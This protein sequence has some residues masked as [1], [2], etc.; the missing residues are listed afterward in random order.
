[1]IITKWN[2]LLDSVIYKRESNEGMMAIVSVGRDRE[3]NCSTDT[4]S[5]KQYTT[6]ERSVAI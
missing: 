5:D 2:F 3:S 6:F 1:M 4:V